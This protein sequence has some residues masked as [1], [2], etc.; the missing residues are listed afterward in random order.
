MRMPSRGWIAGAAVLACA[1]PVAPLAGVRGSEA[2]P[3]GCPPRTGSSTERVND[4]SAG[5]QSKSRAL[6]ATVSANGRFVAFS[7]VGADLVPN[8][9]NRQVDVFV[10]ELR[11]D[12]TTRVSV[13]S[14]GR[15]GNA[16]SFFPSI[17]ANGR[18][19]AFRSFATN[20][21]PRDRNGVEDVFVHDRATGVTERVS[22]GQGGREAGA[23]SVTSSISADGSIVAF[24]SGASNLVPNDRNG[25]RDVFVRDRRRGRTLRVSVGARGEANGASEG[26]GI[27]GDG[28]LVVFRSTATNLVGGDTGPF[29]DV[30][31]R[32]WKA[33]TTERVNVSS[34][35]AQANH[36]TYR[37]SISADGRWVAFRSEA[38]NLVPGDANVAA[39]VFEHDRRT[40]TTTRISVSTGGSEAY[41][42]PSHRTGAGRGL[43]SR[44]FLS[45]KGRFAAFGALAPNLVPKDTNRASDV[46]LHDIRTART[47]RASVGDRGGQANGDS[48]V[49]GISGNGSVVVFVSS[50]SNLVVGDTNGRRD[51]FVRFRPARPSGRTCPRAAR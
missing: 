51:V 23:P 25:A 45:A 20:L 37:G 17:S 4:S 27:S 40:G 31:V 50:A 8:D 9:R 28:R 19:V 12:V 7:S 3:R 26:S 10:R 13:S 35:G 18:M 41:A 46:F 14:S 49:M 30:F 2:H 47:V 32:N 6:R 34:A 38:S 22:V 48:F 24:S 16:A 44:A 36:E 39:D 42:P 43:V 5:V 33:G 29:P 1:F 11:R 21:V 15:E